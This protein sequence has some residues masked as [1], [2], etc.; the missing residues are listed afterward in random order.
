M[1]MAEA[2]RGTAVEVQAEQALLER[3]SDPHTIEQL[4]RLLDKLDQA[5]F[6][7]EMVEGF[8]RRG[9]EIAESVNDVVIRMR[10]RWAAPEQGTAWG[11][12]LDALRRLRE[13]LDSPQV[14]TLLRSDVLDVRSVRVVGKL[15]R[16]MIQAAED[17]GRGEAKRIG[18]IGILR[19]LG[20]PEVQG[21]L[22]FALS[23][24]RHLSREL[25]HA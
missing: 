12:L 20:D 16:A 18:L 14:Q 6:L 15:A 23:F 11:D 2:G 9:P 4:S 1:R 7:F 25:S 5:V 24:A 8:L 3:L 21:A 19:A 22:H 10:Q 17:V 13:L